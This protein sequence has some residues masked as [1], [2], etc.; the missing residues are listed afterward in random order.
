[1]PAVNDGPSTRRFSP[2][3]IK[4]NYT[5]TGLARILNPGRMKDSLREAHGSPCL[6]AAITGINRR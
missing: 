1:M 5:L 3:H 4:G 2:V 6:Y